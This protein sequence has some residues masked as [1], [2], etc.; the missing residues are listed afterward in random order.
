MKVTFKNTLFMCKNKVHST[1]FQCERSPIHTWDTAGFIF[2]MV[3]SLVQF[4]PAM[5]CFF[6]LTLIISGWLFWGEKEFFD[7]SIFS[8]TALT[9]SS[10]SKS[11][12]SNSTGSYVESSLSSYN[13]WSYLNLVFTIAADYDAE[14]RSLAS[15]YRMLT[16]S[17]GIVNGVIFN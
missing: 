1:A 13:S 16:S 14:C 2:F 17:F 5:S 3:T 9:F 15:Y 7:F 4:E 11:L 12:L 8:A 6:K 10:S